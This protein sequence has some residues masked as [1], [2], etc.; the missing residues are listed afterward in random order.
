MSVGVEAL[1]TSA[2]G[3]QAPW[4]VTKADLDTAQRRIDFEVSCDA[5]Q[6][7]CPVCNTKGQGVHDR[8]KRSWRHLDFSQF[9][10]WLHADVPR[11]DCSACG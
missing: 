3:L 10:A 11:I 5:R 6:M 7:P 9:E 1:F 2:L 4:F 8:I